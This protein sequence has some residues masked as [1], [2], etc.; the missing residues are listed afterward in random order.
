LSVNFSATGHIEL[1]AGNDAA[2]GAQVK[3]FGPVVLDVGGDLHVADVPSLPS[4]ESEMIGASIAADAGGTITIDDGAVL[5]SATGKVTNAPP[6]LRIGEEDPDKVIVPGDTFQELVGNAGGI[7]PGENLELGENFTITVTW[8]DGVRNVVTGVDSSQ[9][10]SIQ[11]ATDGT[12]TVNVGDDGTNYIEL[13]VSR[14]YS[15]TYLSTVTANDVFATIEWENDPNIRLSDSSGVDLNTVSR[16][17]ATQLGSREFQRARGVPMQLREPAPIPV[18]QVTAPAPVSVAVP[19]LSRGRTTDLQVRA[20]EVVEEERKLYI[21]RVGADG[22]EVDK[23]F[24]PEGALSNLSALL[25]RFKGSAEEGREGLPNGLYRIYLEEV[26][27]PRRKV[28][29][30][31]KSGDTLGEQV[32]PP[33]RG[34]MPILDQGPEIP[35]KEPDGGTAHVPQADGGHDPAAAQPL[36]GTTPA[37]SAEQTT[38]PT[39][40]SVDELDP[41]GDGAYA[42]AYV[43]FHGWARRGGGAAV[44]AAGSLA[45]YPALGRW[46]QSIDRAMADSDERSFG[47]AA[48]LRRRFLR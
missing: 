41:A 28:M 12:A 30:F 40:S 16:V 9:E 13:D 32:R 25:E 26:G 24:L 10:L 6:V 38:A 31:Y 17:V 14:E 42:D 39:G 33:G 3:A 2:V 19:P 37:T 8:D 46:Q 15:V 20:E 45:A 29:E 47:K 43:P 36:Q 11:V 23:R 35:E 5:E 22:E 48:R 27:F 44:L 1:T 21:V 18:P 7:P 4:G 34:S